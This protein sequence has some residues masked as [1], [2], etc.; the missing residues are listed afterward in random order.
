MFSVAAPLAPA[1]AASRWL[2]LA[3]TFAARVGFGMQFIA[4][5]ALMPEVRAALALDHGQVGM[6]LGVFMVTGIFLSLPGSMIANCLGDRRSMGLG[7]ALLAGGGAVL[8]LSD[9]YGAAL[10]ARLVGG[11][12][13]V[14]VSVV[15]A[16]IITDRFAGREIATAMSVLGVAWPVGLALGL[17]LLPLFAY[18]SDWRQAVLATA[19]LPVAAMAL[20]GLL[21]GPRPIAPADNHRRPFWRIGR[22]EAWLIIIGGLAWPLMSS[23]GYVVFSS[24]APELLVARGMTMAEAAPLVGVL[25]W[26]IVATIPLGGRLADR[27]GWGDRLFWG[28]CLVAAGAIAA[29][30]LGGAPILWIAIAAALGL[31]VG[32]IMALPSE[33]LAPE[34]RAT[35][36]GL[37]YTLYFLGT[38]LHPAF[39]G[40][41]LEVS[42]SLDLVIWST[43]A[44]LVLAPLALGTVRLLQRRFADQ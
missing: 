42:G 22:R 12:G 39:A 43:A 3:V 27:R 41:L 20:L 24:Y 29:L 28:G 11:A 37:F 30:P 31:T 17:T 36:V 19:L 18:W 33:I 15:S 26:L 7:L 1:F 38:A 32:M 25:S 14:L 10:A 6:L 16:K 4:V 2:V 13:G 21:Q 35:G 5:A 8:A 40:W 44:C 9:A 34:S 23:G